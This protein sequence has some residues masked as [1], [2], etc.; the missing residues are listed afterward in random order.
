MLLNENVF[1][2][3]AFVRRNE[4]E[5]E[6]SQAARKATDLIR[7]AKWPSVVV[8]MLSQRLE[9]TRRR[10]IDTLSVRLLGVATDLDA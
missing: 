7:E 10:F 5:D 9:E 2:D 8:D 6:K 4:I 3:D 1:R